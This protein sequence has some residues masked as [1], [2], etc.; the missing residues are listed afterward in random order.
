MP[1]ARVKCLGQWASGRLCGQEGT[2]GHQGAVWSRVVPCGSV[3]FLGPRSASLLGDSVHLC[4]SSALIT[5]P[6]PCLTPS[7]LPLCLMRDQTPVPVDF[8]MS[9]L[10]PVVVLD[11]LCA[12]DPVSSVRVL[13]TP[14]VISE[15]S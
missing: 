11:A 4:S 6:G 3:W 9:Q 15:D 8:R 13:T 5:R 10:L 1:S 2:L 14:A 7:L 12:R